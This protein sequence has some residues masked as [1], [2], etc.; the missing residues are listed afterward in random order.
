MDRKEFLEKLADARG[1]GKWVKTEDDALRCELPW[2]WDVRTDSRHVCCPLTAVNII[3]GGPYVP[4]TDAWQAGDAFGL[5]PNETQVIIDSADGQ[6]WGE[7]DPELR[8]KMM[9]A[10]GLETEARA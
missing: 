7:G 9:E 1:L 3:Q 8:T 2:T 10:V 4:S 6:D 5:P